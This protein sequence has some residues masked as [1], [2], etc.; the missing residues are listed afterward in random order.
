M[1]HPS[2]PLVS[3]LGG[4]VHGALGASFLLLGGCSD[5]KA[6]EGGR[7]RPVSSSGRGLMRNAVLGGQHCHM[8]QPYALALHTEGFPVFAK[9]PWREKEQPGWLWSA[10][11]TP[12][13]PLNIR[14]SASPGAAAAPGHG[15]AG[16]PWMGAVGLWGAPGSAVLPALRSWV[17]CLA[18][19]F[20]PRI[21]QV[22]G[23]TGAQWGW[24]TAPGAAAG[25]APGLGVT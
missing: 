17:A 21:R 12:R 7:G 20:C 15:A 22:G 24:P 6:F 8:V 5:E 2:R 1:E 14:G 13:S 9:G 10:L 18:E 11:C 25:K 3:R 16:T 4:Q 23:L 19:Q